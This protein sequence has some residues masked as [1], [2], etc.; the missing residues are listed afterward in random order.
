MVT[1]SAEFEMKVWYAATSEPGAT[2]HGYNELICDAGGVYTVSIADTYME[3]EVT[4]SNV[5]GEINT[6]RM[7]IILQQG[8][9]DL[10]IRT[11]EITAPEPM[12][13]FSVTLRTT[14][15]V[16]TVEDKTEVDHTDIVL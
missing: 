6:D 10:I 2:I 14:K 11:K 7:N 9:Y 8:M 15:L 1:E 16:D 5:Q 12:K 3:K 13:L 4:L